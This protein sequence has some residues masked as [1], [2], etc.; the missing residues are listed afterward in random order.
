M[1]AMLGSIVQSRGA[2]YLAVVL[3][4]VA[5]MAIGALFRGQLDDTIVAL[6][7]LLVVLFIATL[8]GRGP[9]MVA[10]VLGMLCYNFLLLFLLLPAIRP[11]YG[12]YSFTIIHPQE[13]M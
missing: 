1:K 3:S 7:L 4:I 11:I 2:G 9:G 12:T 10:A 6:T 8:C 13:S 5:V